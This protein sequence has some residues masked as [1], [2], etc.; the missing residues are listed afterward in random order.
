MTDEL[1]DN[2]VELL[3]ILIENCCSCL[4]NTRNGRNY[5]NVCTTCYT[6]KQTKVFYKLNMYKINKK[7]YNLVR[8]V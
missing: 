2:D 5:C 1:F 7:N 4:S 8:R 3:K 6:L